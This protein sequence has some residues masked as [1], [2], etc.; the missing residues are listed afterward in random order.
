[1]A[2]TCMSGGVGVYLLL[3]PNY[4]CTP[5]ACC[6][7][8]TSSE[9]AYYNV[10]RSPTTFDYGCLASAGCVDD[11]QVDPFDMAEESRLPSGLLAEDDLSVCPP[12]FAFSH[13]SPANNNYCRGVPCL[14][15]PMPAAE[16]V[17]SLDCFVV[18]ASTST[19]DDGRRMEEDDDADFDSAV[20]NCL[21]T[22][23]DEL[24]LK[25]CF[26]LSRESSAFCRR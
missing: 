22:S 23:C 20:L 17:E 19:L 9:P 8:S 6:S 13:A 21:P 1:M 14:C 2:L 15:W 18:A 10:L 3:V 7:L 4:V 25:V 24:E 5:W 12:T 16:T 11:D 26:S